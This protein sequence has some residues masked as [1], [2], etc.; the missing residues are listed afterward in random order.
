MP[1]RDGLNV[2][3]LRAYTAPV[4]AR[5]GSVVR[6]RVRRASATATRSTRTRGRCRARMSSATSRWKPTLTYR[7][8]FFEG[9]DPATAAN[10]AFDPLFLGFH[11]WGTVVAG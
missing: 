9:D 3:N 1:G 6:I 5:A 4:P 8:A 2:F 7:Y 11:D 10:E